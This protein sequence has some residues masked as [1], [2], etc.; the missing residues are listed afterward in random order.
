MGENM[1][2]KILVVDNHPVILKFMTNLLEKRGHQ[3]ITAEDGLSA[4]GILKTY[5]PDIIFVDLVMPNIGGEK[6]CKIIRSRPTLKDAYLIILS[7]VAVEEKMDLT[8]LGANAYIAKGPLNTMAQHILDTINQ[9][10][11]EV[12]ANFP[13]K[14]LGLEGINEREITRELL[15]FKRHSEIILNNMS[16]GIVEL[17]LEGRIIYANPMAISLTSILEEKLLASKFVDLFDGAFRERVK[18]MLNVLG[19]TPKA[20]IADSPLILNNRQVSLNVLPVKEKENKSIVLILNDITERKQAEKKVEEYSK[21]LERMVEE[22]TM[23]LNRALYDTEEARDKIDGILKSVAD[24]LIVTDIYNRIILMNRAAEDLLGVHLTEVITRP[25]DFAIEDETLRERVKSTLDKKKEGYQFDFELP[26]EDP[27]NP[28]IMRARTSVIEDRAG[29]QTGM[30]TIIHDV[31][32]EREVDRMKTEFI[33]TA[34]HELRTPLTSIQGFSEV[35]SRR[36][37]IKQRER[38]KFLTYIND[39]SVNLANII[40]DLLD[41]SRIESGMGF[42]LNK[43]SSDI[44]E[45]IRGVVFFFQEQS[46]K[47]RFEMDLPG[48]PVEM[49]VDREKMRQLIENILSNAVKYS[50][51]GGVIRVRGELVQNAD[52]GFRNAELKHK[53]VYLIS[54]QDEGIGMTQ[55]QVDQIF[56]K[57][58]RVDAS[59]TIISG[60]GLGMSIVRYLVEAHGGKVWVESESGKGTRVVFGIPLTDNTKHI[61]GDI[62]NE[63]S[64]SKFQ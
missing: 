1:K 64:I 5:I 48:R 47:H 23:E 26:G 49:S 51:D 62:N 27:K 40:N 29:R 13:E 2:K 19:D 10:C 9:S 34:A 35:L 7:A 63:V 53:D 6:L 20:I 54:V 31:T 18:D 56:D 25:I 28:R 24:G 12:S 45:I 17:N 36:G 21:D 16:E 42:S 11:L 60:T 3:V 32:H 44:T 55:E 41:I 8:R 59:N 43:I 14:I 58:Y 37:D 15:S 46:P 38:R 61:F 52:F 30:I 33:S 22:R 4:L 50:P 57:F 39:Q